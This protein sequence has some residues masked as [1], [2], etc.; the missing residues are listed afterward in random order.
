[1]AKPL[2]NVV[3]K[4]DGPLKLSDVDSSLCWFSCHLCEKTF[5]NSDDLQQHLKET[6]SGK[7]RQHAYLCWICREQSELKS[8]PKAGMLIKHLKHFHKI[9]RKNID[10]ARIA[11]SNGKD[12]AAV[13]A[14]DA[15]PIQPPMSVRKLRV[16]GESTYNCARCEFSCSER[17]SFLDHIKCHC[18]ENSHQCPECGVCFVVLPSLKRHLM[19]VHRVRDFDRYFAETGFSL[20]IPTSYDVDSDPEDAHVVVP[21]TSIKQSNEELASSPEKESSLECTVCYRTFGD[22]CAVRQHMRVHGMAFIQG[23][24]RSNMSRK[25]VSSEG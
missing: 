8:Y 9:A 19:I 25:S 1:M 10:Y 2:S 24:R 17:V 12:D 18:R 4:L 21:N 5:R 7:S 16:E 6:H 3:K 15:K 13:T 20:D 11:L 14:D 23:T 22:E